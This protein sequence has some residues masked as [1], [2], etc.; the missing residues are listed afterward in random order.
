MVF[1]HQA[2][3]AFGIILLSSSTHPLHLLSFL[4]DLFSLLLTTG[5]VHF[6]LSKVMLFS[7]L[8]SSVPLSH[9]IVS[10]SLPLYQ[11]VAVFS[12]SA[13]HHCWCTLSA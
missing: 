11:L 2:S 13:G 7:Y 12:P 4:I 3:V 10:L 1:F 8:P 6:V 9:Q 5:L